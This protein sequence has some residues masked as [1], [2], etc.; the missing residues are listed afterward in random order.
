MF[1]KESKHLILLLKIQ[2]EAKVKNGIRLHTA[3]VIDRK[4]TEQIL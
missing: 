2:S 1:N 3:H 4:I